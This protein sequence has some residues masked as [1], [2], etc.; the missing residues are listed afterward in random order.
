[1][2]PKTWIPSCAG[3]TSKCSTRYNSIEYA[4]IPR[5]TLRSTHGYNPT[6]LQGDLLTLRIYNDMD[7][8]TVHY[9]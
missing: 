3:M 6:P 9:G 2:N 4:L 5:V 8:Q 7:E 1:M